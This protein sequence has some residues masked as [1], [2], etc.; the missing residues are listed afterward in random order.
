MDREARDRGT[1]PELEECAKKNASLAGGALDAPEAEAAAGAGEVG[2]A[3]DST[4][5]DVGDTTFCCR[6]ACFQLATLG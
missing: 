1:G 6:P 4:L 5:G 3:G 2:D